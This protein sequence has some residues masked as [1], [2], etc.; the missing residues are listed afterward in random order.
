MDFATH[1]EATPALVCIGA[2]EMNE[3]QDIGY[4]LFYYIIYFIILFIGGVE[5][6]ESVGAPKLLHPQFQ[7]FLKLL[8]GH[9]IQGVIK[10]LRCLPKSFQM[11]SNRQDQAC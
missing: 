3:E 9:D 6:F 8:H 10:N 7:N 4:Y 11:L 1:V 5:Q 2:S